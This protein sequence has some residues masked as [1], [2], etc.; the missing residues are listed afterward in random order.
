MD[1][2]LEPEFLGLVFLG[3][4]FLFPLV[5]FRL[6]RGHARAAAIGAA[7][8][9]WATIPICLAEAAALA[10]NFEE[11]GAPLRGS[12]WPPTADLLAL[13]YAPFALLV[14][15]MLRWLARRQLLA[16]EREDEAALL[17]FAKEDLGRSGS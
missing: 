15:V 14:A 4:G 8:M 16:D 11:H 13:A 1:A 6:A 7:I 5:L 10:V 3:A 12:W 9:M 17:E 2:L